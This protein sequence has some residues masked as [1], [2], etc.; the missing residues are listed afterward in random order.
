M[1]ESE[2]EVPLRLGSGHGMDGP[3]CISGNPQWPGVERTVMFPFAG[4]FFVVAGLI[5]Y[6]RFISDFNDEGFGLDSS[7]C[8]CCIS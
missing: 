6:K 3:L 1:V 2:L 5:Y 8:S 7:F 4:R